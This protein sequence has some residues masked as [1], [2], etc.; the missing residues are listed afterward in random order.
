MTADE[1]C[2]ITWPCMPISVA[3]ESANACWRAAWQHSRQPASPKAISSFSE[4]TR[5]RQFWIKVGAEERLSLDF[6]SIA[7]DA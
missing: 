7:T 5:S 4:T 3:G 6:F 2:F 1:D